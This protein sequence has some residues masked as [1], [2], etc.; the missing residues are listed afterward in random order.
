MDRRSFLYLSSLTGGALA[1]G[2]LSALQTQDLIRLT[3]GNTEV[4]RVPSRFTGLSYESRQLGD[5]SFFSPQNAPLIAAFRGLGKGVLRIG[6]NT[7][8]YCFFRKDA[9]PSGQPISADP[10]KG[11]TAPP[12]TTITPVAIR[13]LR[14]FLDACDWQCIYGLNLGKGTPDASANEAAFVADTLGSRLDLVQIGNEPDLFPQNGLR[15]KT[16]SFEDFANEW[17]QH[18][19]AVRKRVPKLR[20]AGPADA[21]NVEWTRKFAARFHDRIDLLTHHYYAEGPPTD[22]TMNI[23]RLLRI[24]PQRQAKLF[25][26]LAAIAS[27]HKLPW[28]LAETNSC[29]SGGKEGVSN[30]FASALWGA[31]MMFQLAQAGAVGL[32]FHGG[33][34]GWYTPIAGSAEERPLYA[35]MQLFDRAAAKSMMALQVASELPLFSAYAMRNDSGQLSLALFNKDSRTSRTL[36]IPFPG[37]SA[38]SVV[39]MR[40]GS[41]ESIDKPTFKAD[42]LSIQ[43]SR[44][45]RFDITTAEARLVKL[46]HR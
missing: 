27:E 26:D 4:S 14:G 3:I 16:W 6:G 12:E 15:A 18:F 44:L 20:F 35:G 40:A 5:P 21:F 33:G 41:L 37:V 42:A 31:D 39:E 29:Y 13:N 11:R 17:Q 25:A 30:T 2:S 32:N 7:S 46:T 43:G 9:Q 22:S 10:D 23:D 24:A 28:R 36:E 8:E 19:E 1:T 45:I 34:K 38:A